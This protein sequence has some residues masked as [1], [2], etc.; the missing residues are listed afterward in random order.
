MTDKQIFERVKKHLLKQKEQATDDE[1]GT[2]G[3]RYRGVDGLKCA[4]GC[5]ITNAAYTPK[6][7][8][9]TPN[10]LGIRGGRWIF[11]PL[12]K[13]LNQSR[14]PARESTQM[15][16][17]TLQEIHDNEEPIEWRS[18]LRVKDFKFDAKGMYVDEGAVQ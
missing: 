3:C 12:A 2:G 7:E 14:I 18:R 1:N 8:G 6:C 9:H 15:L 5:L 13:A 11:G 16:L 17:S 4:V 10:E